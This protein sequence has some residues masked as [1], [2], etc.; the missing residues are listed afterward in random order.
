M[1]LSKVLHIAAIKE[2]S[3]NRIRL[4]DYKKK[5]GGLPRLFRDDSLTLPI[6]AIG[7]YGVSARLLTWQ[8]FK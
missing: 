4:Q 1:A 3:G 5:R 7:G 6:L 8:V 2:A